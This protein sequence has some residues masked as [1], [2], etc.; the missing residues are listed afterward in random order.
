MK[1][2][3]TVV[4]ASVCSS[5]APRLSRDEIK[6]GDAQYTESHAGTIIYA[7]AGVKA[8]SGKTANITAAAAGLYYYDG[9][10]GSECF[11]A[12]PES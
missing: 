11:R 4:M 6:A 12:T 7:T 3:L 5:A 1:P 10:Y 2:T 8:A 9:R